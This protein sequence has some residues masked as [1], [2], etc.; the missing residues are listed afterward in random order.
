MTGLSRSTRPCLP[1]AYA[2]AREV[3]V[4]RRVGS[5]PVDDGP[6]RASL[7][8][9]HRRVRDIHGR[10]V[11]LDAPGPVMARLAAIENDLA[12]RENALESAARGWFHAKRD[13]EHR[14]AVAFMRASGTV[15]ERNAAADI[16]TAMLGAAEEAEWEALKAVV[17][18]LETR[19][20]I[21]QSI[22][23][24]QGRA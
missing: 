9:V 8:E 6:D 16:E 24:S 20:S 2:P 11:M 3:L 17:R 12:A 13:K 7:P 5:L 4:V 15:A 18:V 10:R 23:R 22:L 21:G 1:D 19:A 14:R